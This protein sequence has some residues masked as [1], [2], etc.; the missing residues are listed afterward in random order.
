MFSKFQDFLL[1]VVL[2][3]AIYRI[4]FGEGMTTVNLFILLCAVVAVIS[5]ALKRSGAY[6]RAHREKEEAM[7]KKNEKDQ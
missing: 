7:K 1:V 2:F 4:G 6:D 3:Y 5:M